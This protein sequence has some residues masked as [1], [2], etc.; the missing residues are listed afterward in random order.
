MWC[1][2]LWECVGMLWFSSWGDTFLIGRLDTQGTGRTVCNFWPRVNE[3]LRMRSRSEGSLFLA[4]GSSAPRSSGDNKAPHI[5]SSFQGANRARPYIFRGTRHTAYNKH[6]TGWA[7]Q[8]TQP[9][10]HP[11]RRAIARAPRASRSSSERVSNHTSGG[12]SSDCTG[13]DR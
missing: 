9:R 12:R 10:K 4:P 7:L 5:F 6:D 1:G 3:F 11:L 8:D 2:V 13:S